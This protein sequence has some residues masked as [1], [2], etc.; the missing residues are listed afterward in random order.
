MNAPNNSDDQHRELA[1]KL[2][3]ALLDPADRYYVGCYARQLAEQ[4][5][6][7]AAPK[8]PALA[9]CTLPAFELKFQQ[10]GTLC[11]GDFAIPAGKSAQL[12]LS[13]GE[14]TQMVRIENGLL[15]PTPPR[16]HAESVFLAKVETEFAEKPSP[17]A[18]TFRITR[19]PTNI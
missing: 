10:D 11:V 13:A 4:I 7:Q 16:K 17:A 1:A 18:E 14:Y 2:L 5:L 9:G 6:A 8:E 15:E 3:Q 19:Y 12:H